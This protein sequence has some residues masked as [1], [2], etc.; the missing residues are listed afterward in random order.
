[1]DDLDS[2]IRNARVTVRGS[3]ASSGNLSVSFTDFLSGLAAGYH[4]ANNLVR[5]SASR[6]TTAVVNP[7]G[8]STDV[9]LSSKR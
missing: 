5:K 7:G 3:E 9:L 8:W 6:A 2:T 4:I 1:M